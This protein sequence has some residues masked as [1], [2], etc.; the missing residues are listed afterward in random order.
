MPLA[1]LTGGLSP[2]TQY[3][4]ETGND[5]GQLTNRNS[6]SDSLPQTAQ[7]CSAL[8]SLHSDKISVGGVGGHG[9]LTSNLQ[10]CD[11]ECEE[12]REISVCEGHRVIKTR[13]SG[14]GGEGGG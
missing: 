14:G 1:R 12:A 4:R 5:R 10:C 11:G 3:L 6:L 9:D 2:L 13:L 7:F 8:H